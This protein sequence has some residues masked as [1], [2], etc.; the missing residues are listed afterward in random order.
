MRTV[1]AIN[2][3]HQC[4]DRASDGRVALRFDNVVVEWYGEQHT[5]ATW[6]EWYLFGG[7]N[8]VRYYMFQTGLVSYIRGVI[9]DGHYATL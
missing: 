2:G 6:I 5:P 8:S 3:D 9:A 1:N 4:L 7:S